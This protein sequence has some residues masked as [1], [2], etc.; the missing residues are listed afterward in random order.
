MDQ[1]LTV[2]GGDL[3]EHE[4]PSPARGCPDHPG[5]AQDGSVLRFEMEAEADA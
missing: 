2:A 3:I 1:T 4:R 5:L